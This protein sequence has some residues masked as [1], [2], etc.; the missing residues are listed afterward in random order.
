M[1]NNALLM[2][3]ASAAASVPGRYD[4]P[5]SV[6]F[7]PDDTTL[8]TRTLDETPTDASKGILSGWFKK[9]GQGISQDMWCAPNQD[10]NLQ[11]QTGDQITFNDHAYET[12]RWERTLLDPAA[13]YHIVCS[14]DSD[15]VVVEDRVIVYVNGELQTDYAY[16]APTQ[17]ALAEAWGMTQDGVVVRVGNNYADGSIWDGYIAQ[18]VCIDGKSIQ[19]GDYSIGSFGEYN[20]NVWRPVDL[21]GLTFGNNG[22]LLDFADSS[23]LGNDVSGNNN[24]F[25]SSGLVAA[26]QVTD[27]PTTNYPTLNPLMKGG[28]SVILSDG[29][30]H[31]ELDTRGRVPATIAVDVHDSEGWYW[32]CIPLD[33]DHTNYCAA[34]WGGLDIP[35]WDT[36]ASYFSAMTPAVSIYINEGGITQN[37]SAVGS[38]TTALND[39]DVLGCAVRNGKVY[40]AKNNT[41][42]NSGDPV[43]E[44]GFMTTIT[45]TCLFY[46]VVA[47]QALAGQPA[48]DVNFGQL[49]FA[50][51]PPT[52]YKAINTANF[53]E[54]TIQNSKKYF[55]TILYEG[56]GLSQKVGQFQPI[57]EDYSVG[58]SALWVAAD[59]TF[60]F[61]TPSSAGNRKT[62]SLS[63]WCKRGITGSIMQ[64]YNSG[65]GNDITFNASDKLTFAD[66]S[67]VSYI[68]TQLFQDATQWHHFLFAWDTTLATAGD[69]LRIYHNGVEITAFDTETNPSLGDEFGISNT[70]RQTIGA[71]E[72]DTEE[73]D[74]YLSEI[75]FVDSLQLTPSDFGS[76][77]S[78]TN[79]WIPKQYTI[80]STGSDITFTATGSAVDATGATAYTSS[81]V[82]IGTVTANRKVVIAVSANYSG[83]KTV[84]TM[85]V[86]GESAYYLSRF[87][88]GGRTTEI[89]AIDDPDQSLGTSEDIVT[90]WS[91]AT[92]GQGLCTF[93]VKN[94]DSYVYDS[95][96]ST[97]DPLTG[98]VSVPAGGMSIGTFGVGI[99][100]DPATGFTFTS[101]LTSRFNLKVEAS[102]YFA[103][104]ADVQS[105]ATDQ[106][107]VVNID[108]S[109]VEANGQCISLSPTGGIGR[110]GFYLNF[111][112]TSN[113]GFDAAGSAISSKTY[114][115]LKMNV[116]GVAGSTT[117]IS[118]GELELYAG[119]VKNPT[120]TMTGNSA[121]SPLV[122][123]ASE[124]TGTGAE[125]AFKAFDDN[126]N[127]HWQ[128][129][130]GTVTGWVKID[131]GSGNEIAPGKIGLGTAETPDRTPSTFTIQGSNN[132]SDYTTLATYTSA[133]STAPAA[134]V[135]FYLPLSNGGNNWISSAGFSPSTAA[136]TFYD[137]PTRNFAIMDP[138]R[139][140]NE[141][142]TKG[143]L[144]GT[145]GGATGQVRTPDAFGLTSGKWYFEYL[146]TNGSTNE[147][148]MYITQNDVAISATQI[149]SLTGHY[150]GYYSYDGDARTPGDPGSTTGEG[151]DYGDTYTS[152]DVIS[153]AV[154]LDLGAI[155]WG[156]NGTWQ[157][158]ATE[159]EIEAGNASNA[160]QGGLA[161]GKWYPTM[162]NNTTQASQM[163][164]GQHIYFD[165][166][167]LTLDTTADGYFRHAV[168]DGFK[169]IHV[170][171][172]T[173]SSS[174]ISAFSWIK[175]RD[176][177][178]SH[179][180][181][182]RVRGPFSF[183]HANTD[184]T[185]T[186]DVDTLT[187]FLKQG[188][189]IGDDVRV[190][191][192]NESYVYW[193]WFIEATG[194]GSS[195]EDG[196]INTASTLVDTTSGISISKFEGTGANAT[197]GHGL[198]VAPKF[199]ILKHFDNSGYSSTVFHSNVVTPTTGY[200]VLDSNY[201]EQN[202][203][204][205]WNSTI[206]TSS[207]VSLG[208]SAASNN[209]GT[210]YMMYCFAEIEGFSKFGQYTGNGS[211]SGDGPFTYTG[212]KP[213]FIMC[214]A[215]DRTSD[216]YISDIARN[217]FNSDATANRMVQYA[218]LARA[219]ESGY[220]LQI[221]SN[222]F[223]QYD[224]A[225]N[226]SSGKLYC[227]VAFAYNPFGGASTTPGTAF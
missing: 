126:I 162:Q 154:D 44:S 80:T 14:Y 186:D 95:F 187:R 148:T 92:V 191:T 182:D 7:N 23:D 93:D 58:N 201:A 30:L 97:A 98:T 158:S 49:G 91:G 208:T 145:S 172:L 226:N 20:N 119:L 66:T 115:Y 68:T 214:K 65:A 195:N 56:N 117:Y 42:M 78:T 140:I 76:V 39:D 227:Y 147:R 174:F 218:N 153:C 51:D 179:M 83:T 127:T 90:T 132:D 170:D 171:H 164:F 108:G 141:T 180:N 160:A 18:N 63:L 48:L 10:F 100:A 131:L 134:R 204:A 67:G 103:A 85:T 193:D 27:T 36:T 198:G 82:S 99:G 114:R 161:A 151:T 202:N 9:S 1:F 124:D 196:S 118:V 101:G 144:L 184:A 64:L 11:M 59:S 79:R 46:P 166:T 176:A 211:G 25:T 123:S 217:K 74:G 177:T 150:S 45:E 70:V 146:M 213:N 31:A 34:G 15:R 163:N 104:G 157:N 32:E 110:N 138:G 12:K 216:W 89:W 173:E 40:F 86:G 84:S 224:G 212:F 54:P 155:W 175:N 105:T 94:S 220:G 88:N 50:Y 205:I 192:A 225:E 109:P 215:V 149:R 16:Y 21:T 87:A 112:E 190:N 200:L 207:V 120:S 125:L 35:D 156:K 33:I 72:S 107:P 223:K 139:S 135:K 47:D 111:S 52:G 203:A 8:L 24:D 4:I 113:M 55:D 22:W 129:A 57:E 41:W 102:E 159:A 106:T 6:R 96:T 178:D 152:G 28:G 19:N 210:D 38:F 167:A 221:F 69:R 165:S 168:P 3:A 133:F 209:S 188:A 13:W 53:S 121:P 61:R 37:G 222:G 169:A 219:D 130:N 71:N 128:T 199:V 185:I 73:F 77:D 29:S 17:T 189:T 206:P 137:T 60:L 142:M 43:A 75:Y 183:W 122:A 136:Y 26:D 181:F 197:V 143:N 81:A 62:G 2:A 5:Y 116:T 194:S